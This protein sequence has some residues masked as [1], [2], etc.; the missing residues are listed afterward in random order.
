M[1]SNIQNIPCRYPQKEIT[2]NVKPSIIS[3]CKLNIL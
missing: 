1:K 3:F 2:Q